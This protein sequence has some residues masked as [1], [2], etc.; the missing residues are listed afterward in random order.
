[1]YRVLLRPLLFLLQAET[2]HRLVMFAMGLLSR[3]PGGTALLALLYG[4]P[5]PVL[6]VRAFGREL[7]SPIGLA[8]GLDK[9]A[10]AYEAFGALGF[11]FV[12]VGTIT[13]QAQPGNPRPRLFRLRAD[14]AVFNG[15]DT[16][17]GF[18][19]V[20]HASSGHVA[21]RAAPL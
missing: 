8:A 1:M 11:G 14:R 16:E 12:E 2:A 5:D 13:G 21:L 17:A 20:V 19:E 10:E 9:D 7:A 3:L 4:R 6:R 15:V 18:L